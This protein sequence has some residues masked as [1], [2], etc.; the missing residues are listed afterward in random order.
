MRM[1]DDVILLADGGGGERMMD[2]VRR[3][4]L[5]RFA[6]ADASGELA[7][8]SDA[9]NI[10]RASQRSSMSRARSSMNGSRVT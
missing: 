7:R 10:V 1:S 6:A 2:L 8:L 3:E 5:A 4:I 9:A